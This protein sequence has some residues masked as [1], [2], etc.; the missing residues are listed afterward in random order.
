VLQFGKYHPPVPGGIET[1]ALELTRGLNRAGIATDVLC[2]GLSR[3]TVV[4]RADTGYRIVRAGSWGRLLSTAVSPAMVAALREVRDE[5][6]LIHLHMPDP[7]AALAL[8]AVR[9]ASRLVLH[10]HS[11]VVRQRAAMHA[12]RPLQDRLLERADAIVATSLAYAE[13]SDALRRWRDKVTVIPIGVSDS[14]AAAPEERVQ[15]IRARYA[16]RRI[17]FALGRM[18]HYKGFTV[19]ARAAS[20]LPDDCVV[21]IGG[22]GIEFDALRRFVAQE[23]LGDRVHVLGHIGGDALPAHYAACDVFCLPSTLRA[24]AF[25][26]SIVEALLMGKPVVAT[27]IPGSGVP[28]VNLHGVTGLNAPAGDPAA[29]AD[30]LATLTG[31]PQ[32]RRRLGAAA[33]RRYLDEFGV[34][35]MIDRT[36]RLYESLGLPPAPLPPPPRPAHGLPAGTRHRP[37]ARDRRGPRHRPARRAPRAGPPRLTAPPDLSFRYRPDR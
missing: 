7:M 24:E 22:D 21:L 25:G 35:R 1:V 18:T 4:E 2:A 3:R 10:W 17:V 32:L 34:D 20:M 6:D 12:Y 31:D 33:R 30:A 26:V 36:L 5:Y 8:M 19:L 11:D 27:D 16:G 28:W 9:P 29:L 14:H 23:R 15:A 13:S 37:L